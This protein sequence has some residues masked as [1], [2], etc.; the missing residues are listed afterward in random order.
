MTI[1]DQ[2]PNS[3][4]LDRSGS[5]P[6]YSPISSSAREIRELF[7]LNLIAELY[8]NNR[9]NTCETS[10]YIPEHNSNVDIFDKPPDY[11]S[12][13]LNDLSEQ[14]NRFPAVHQKDAAP[15]PPYKADS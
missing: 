11:E 3:V 10:G 15:P 13:V 5:H 12:V 8:S 14:V 2:N 7:I 6:T 4:P 9:R 1:S